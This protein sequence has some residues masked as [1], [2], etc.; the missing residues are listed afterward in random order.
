M[1]LAEDL[2]VPKVVGAG[3][4]ISGAVLAQVRLR[5]HVS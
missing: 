4:V 2:T 1:L 3:L 5:K